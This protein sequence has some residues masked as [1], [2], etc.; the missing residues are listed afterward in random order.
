MTIDTPHL[1][2]DEIGARSSRIWA[3]ARE[4]AEKTVSGSWPWIR[5][6]SIPNPRARSASE[7]RTL[8][9]RFR[10]G[11]PLFWQTN[12]TDADS[13]A[14]RFIASDMSPS[15]VAPSPMYTMTKSSRPCNRCPIE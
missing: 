12:S 1:D 8:L 11:P 4:Q 7:V 3:A 2:L 10:D 9:G 5:T 14:A 6:D 15:L 13:T